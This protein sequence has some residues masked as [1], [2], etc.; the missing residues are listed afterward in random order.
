MKNC[1]TFKADI[2]VGLQEGYDGHIYR[3]GEVAKLCQEYCD[4]TGFGVTVTP[5]EFI[6]TDGNETG[7]I[8]GIINYP[9]FPRPRWKNEVHAKEIAKQCMEAFGQERIS[10][11]MTDKTIMLERDAED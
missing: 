1:K 5:T 2:Y 6:Y 8:V 3:I 4:K 10:I 7:V 11:V 9:R